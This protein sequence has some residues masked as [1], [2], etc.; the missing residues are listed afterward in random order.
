MME[1]IEEQ[2]L[3]WLCKLTKGN[4]RTSRNKDIYTN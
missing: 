1:Q 2:L 4:E 3:E